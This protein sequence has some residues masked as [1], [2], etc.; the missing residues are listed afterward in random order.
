MLKRFFF[1]DC[2]KPFCKKF[3]IHVAQAFFSSDYSN[4]I[5]D[6]LQFQIDSQYGME[7]LSA[8]YPKIPFHQIDAKLFAIKSWDLR[9]LDA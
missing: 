6:K 5:A 4:Y 3:D 8:I 2:S 7:E 9:K 1:I